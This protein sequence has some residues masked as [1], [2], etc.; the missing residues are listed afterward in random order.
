MTYHPLPEVDEDSLLAYHRY[1]AAHLT[2]PFPATLTE[3]T[4]PLD[5]TSS[6]VTVIGLLSADADDEMYGLLC[7]ARQ[8]KH[9]LEVPLGELELK[10]GNPNYQLVDDYL[11]WFWNNR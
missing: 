4:G 2:F 8:G 9:H 6:E 1:L 3:E 11:T 5:V 10:K 7:K